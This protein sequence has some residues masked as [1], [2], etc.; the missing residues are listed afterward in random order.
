MCHK[1]NIQQL[2]YKIPR[3][4]WMTQRKNIAF[5]DEWWHG[6]HNEID[7]Y[8]FQQNMNFIFVNA[9]NHM[10]THRHPKKNEISNSNKTI[11]KIAFFK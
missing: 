1:S 6:L 9:K 3:E 7:T 2:F 10:E 11:Q 4:Y 8:Q 5:Y